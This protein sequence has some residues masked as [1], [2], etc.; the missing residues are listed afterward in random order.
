MQK[1][2]LLR[3]VAV[4]CM[5]LGVEISLI[6]LGPISGLCLTDF[7]YNGIKFLVSTF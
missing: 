7:Q 1:A 2:C 5:W 3:L 6:P 4:C